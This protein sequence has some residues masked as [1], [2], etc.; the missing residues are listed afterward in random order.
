[1]DL[2]PIKERLEDNKRFTDDPDCQDSIFMSIEFYKKIGYNM[3]WICYY[4]QLDGKL[5]GCAAYKGKPVNGKVEIAYGVFPQYWKRGI[6]TQ[7][8]ST[9]IKLSLKTDPLVIITA[10]TRPEENYSTK[11]L[12]KNS[13]RLLGS[14]IDEEDGEVWEWE[15]LAL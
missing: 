11:I 3:L 7:I 14:V 6:G 1:M 8:A 10:K 5:V 15:Y 9:L 4:A 12:H 13:F 2:I